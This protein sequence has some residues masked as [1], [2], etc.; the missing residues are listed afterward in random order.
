MRTQLGTLNLYMILYTNLTIAS[1]V[2]F[3][4]GMVSI[5]LVKVS[6]AMNKNLKPSGALGRTPT[7]SIPQIVK[8]RERL[9][10]RSGFACFV[11]CFKKN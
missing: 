8:G 9:I 1:C 11:V 4:I 6:I 2:I 7:V 3:T 10:G 5:H